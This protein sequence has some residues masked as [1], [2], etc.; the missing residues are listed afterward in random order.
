MNVENFVSILDS[1]FVSILDSEFYTGVPDSLLKSLC[2]YLIE[3][4]GSNKNRH[5]IA[6]NEGNAVALAAGYHLATNKV[7]V[8]YLQ[9]SGEGN[10]LNPVASLLS[11]KIYSIPTIFV[12]GWRGEPGIKDEPQHIMQGIITLDILK[13]L[14]IEYFVLTKDIEIDEFQKVMDGFKE[15][16]SV[17]KQVAFVISK[18]ALTYDKKISYANNYKIGREDALKKIVE[19]AEDD[20]IIS[21]TG[22]ISRELFEIREKNHQSH[23]TDF[24]TVGSMGHTSSIALGIALQKPDKRIWCIDGDGALLMHMGSL[25]VIGANSPK[26]F[27]H[28]VLNNEAHESVGGMPTVAN[29]V[30]FSEIARACNYA[31]TSSIN[32]FKNLDEELTYIKNHKQLTFVEVKVSIGSRKDLGRPTTSPSENKLEFILNVQENW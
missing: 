26:N 6:A 5:V 30:N 15:K 3:K 32:D 27:V 2:N 29:A 14:D 21:T 9:N 7:P 4:F 1:N 17:G 13:V 31:H 25:A 22:K 23:K 11:D 28:V 24:L 19:Y 18:E 20:I 12:I 8:V 10:I 16:L